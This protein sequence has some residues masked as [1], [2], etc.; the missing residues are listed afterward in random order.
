MCAAEHISS[1]HTVNEGSHV[2]GPLYVTVGPGTE[3]VPIRSPAAHN[4]TTR[5][6]QKKPLKVLTISH[7]IAYDNKYYRTQI[8][9]VEV[10]GTEL[11]PYVN[12]TAL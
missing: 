10:M 6:S 3:M 2:Q 4:L 9:G 1:V 8:V 11:V 5:S 7:Q 12:S